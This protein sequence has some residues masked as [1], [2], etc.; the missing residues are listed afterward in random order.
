MAHPEG[1]RR[2]AEQVPGAV[3]WCVGAGDSGLAFDP[4]HMGLVTDLRSRPLWER[5]AAWMRGI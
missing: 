1:A 4:G 2:W 5:V 3:F